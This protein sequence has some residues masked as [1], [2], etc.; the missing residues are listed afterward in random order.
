MVVKANQPQLLDDSATIRRSGSLPCLLPADLA[1]RSGFDE[2]APEDAHALA[3]VPWARGRGKV[4]KVR[5]AVGRW[6]VALVVVGVLALAVVGAGV[7][8]LTMNV[9]GFLALAMIP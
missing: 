7:L 1:F 5:L 8:A 9:A 4:L 2:E 6:L 3:I